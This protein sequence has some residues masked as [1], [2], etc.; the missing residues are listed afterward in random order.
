ML[1]LSVMAN[2]RQPTHH[3]RSQGG[4]LSNGPRAVS[5]A[6]HTPQL[7]GPRCPKGPKIPVP[8]LLRPPEKASIP[9]LKYE[10]L[11]ISE[12]RG[13]FERKVHYS[14]FGPL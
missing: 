8:S 2:A 6:L 3:R 10:S 5:A 1:S 7:G 11:G 9:K 4:L 12:V 14:Y 13:P